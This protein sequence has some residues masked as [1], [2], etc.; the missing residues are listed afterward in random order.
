MQAKKSKFIIVPIR[1]WLK[2]E[3]RFKVSWVVEGD[4]DQ[5]VFVKGANMLDLGGESTKDYKLNFLA[6][7]VGAYKVKITFM[8]DSSGE[9]LSY[10]VQT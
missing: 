6:Y 10:I 3:Q 7:K 5:T 2:S 1:N 4:K 9:Y 8:N